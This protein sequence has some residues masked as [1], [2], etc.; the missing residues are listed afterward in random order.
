MSSARMA[1]TRAQLRE[2]ERELLS[3]R[4]RLER[5][6][7][8]RIGADGAPGWSVGDPRAPSDAAGGLAV[9]LETRTLARHQAVVDALRRLEGGTYGLC[10]RCRAPIPYARLLV[11][12]EAT[13][14]VTCGHRA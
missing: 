10:Q 3:A 11:M 14:C 5:A 6:L 13:H 12:P 8:A 2:L 4:A 9:A 7:M 1:L